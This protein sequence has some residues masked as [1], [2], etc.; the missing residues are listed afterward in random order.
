M[1]LNLKWYKKMVAAVLAGERDFDKLNEIG[2]LM[3][4]ITEFDE[5]VEEMERENQTLRLHQVRADT[6]SLIVTMFQWCLGYSDRFTGVEDNYHKFYE[7]C[8]K[9]NFK[10]KFSPDVG[11]LERLELFMQ[12]HDLVLEHR[13]KQAA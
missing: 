2:L 7:Y 3:Y 4:H 6:G 8:R 13:R 10:F 9:N 5:I 12:T 1:T 11:F